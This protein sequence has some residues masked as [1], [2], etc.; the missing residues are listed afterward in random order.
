MIVEQCPHC[1]VRH[2][3]T[4]ILLTEPLRP[5][6]TPQTYWI[7][8]RCQADACRRLMLVRQGAD[9][10]LSVL[11]P[12]GSDELGPTP[13]IPQPMR[14]DFHEAG[15]CLAAGCFKA[16]LV[17][18]RRV[19]QR[20]LK[21]QGCDQRYLVDQIAQAVKSGILRSSFHPLAEEVRQYGNLGAHP[22]DNDLAVAN[23]DAAKQV[24]EF[25]RLLVQEFYEIPATV[26]RLQQHRQGPQGGNP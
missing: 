7:V 17:M 1:G 4:T 23:R 18:S 24:L 22:D 3:Q 15:V 11:F 21:E 14:A 10:Q 26:T 5:K 6:A 9:R 2:V 16:S 20:C 19:L 25:A 12:L 13:S 8:A